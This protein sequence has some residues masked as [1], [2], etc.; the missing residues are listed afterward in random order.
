MLTSEAVLSETFHLIRGSRRET[1]AVWEQ[2]LLGTIQMAKI[3]HSELPQVQKLMTR[4]ADRPMDFADAS[5]VYLA[6]RECIPSVFTVDQA[7]FAT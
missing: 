7:D 5:L 4:Y 2:I 6:E 1:N 3:E